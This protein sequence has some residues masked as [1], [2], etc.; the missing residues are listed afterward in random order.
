LQKV[1][2][3]VEKGEIPK[4]PIVINGLP[5]VGLVGVIAVSHLISK[6]KMEEVAFFESDMLP[7][8]VVLHKGLPCSPMRI[9][10]HGD[11]LAVISEIAVPAVAV[12]QLAKAIVDWASSIKAR[13]ILSI[14]GIPVPNRQDIEKPAVFATASDEKTLKD[15]RDRKI[16]IMEEGYMVGPYALILKYSAMAGI[17]SIS[18]MAESFPNYP[19][20]EAAATLILELNRLLGLDVDVSELIA[21]GEEIR[22]KARDMMRRTQLELSKMKASQEYDVPPI[23][24]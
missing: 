24:V 18:L 11:L 13:L 3:I 7:P 19:D 8:V 15:L 17:P 21:R 10:R 6:L 16:K 12:H 22:L 9:F 5:G 14:G 23:Y 20:P 1:F 4:N 2:K